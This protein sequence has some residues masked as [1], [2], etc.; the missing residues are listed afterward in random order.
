MA[1]QKRPQKRL[2]LSQ[3]ATS[4]ERQIAT[5]SRVKQDEKYRRDMYL[6]FVNSALH[7]KSMGVTE[8]FDELV[9]Q[10]NTKRTTRDQSAPA[11]QPAQLRLWFSAFSYVV[12]KLEHLHAP[13]VQTIINMPWTTLD[14]ATVKSYIVFLGNLLSAKP[15][16]LSFVLSKIAHGFTYQ[17]GLQALDNAGPEGSSGPLTRRVIY[18]RLHDLL[19]HLLSLIP[20]LPSTLQPLL[21]RNFPHKRQNQIAQTTYIRNLLRVSSYCPGLA[22]KILSTIIDRAIQID[23]EIQV[24]LEELEEAEEAKEQEELFELDPFDVVV[25][26]ES[27]SSS[28]SE[29]ETE[30]DIFSDLSSGPE[31]DDGVVVD[32]P[33]NLKQ[34][35][36]M[37]KKLDVILTLIF[38][39]FEQMYTLT[40]KSPPPPSPP[41]NASSPPLPELPPFPPVSNLF[42]S[43]PITPIYTPS[44]AIPSEK[45]LV[46]EISLLAPPDRLRAQFHA[47]LSIFDHTILRTFKSRYTQ[48]LVFWFASLDPEFADVFQGMLV[49]RALFASDSTPHNIATG[50]SAPDSHN[51]PSSTG[52]TPTVIRAAAASYIGSFVSRATFIDRTNTRHVVGVLCEFLRSHLDAVDEAIRIWGVTSVVGF[53]D[54]GVGNGAVGRAQNTVFYAVAQAVF[55]I[56]CFRWRDLLESEEGQGEDESESWKGVMDPV[57]SVSASAAATGKKWMPELGILQRVVTSILNPLKVCSPNV[58]MQFARVAHA[59][60]FLYCYSILE[61]NKRSEHAPRPSN[62]TSNHLTSTSVVH[63]AILVSETVAT[64]LNTFFPFDPYRLQRSASFIQRIYREWSSV[65]IDDEDEEDEDAEDKAG[66][67]KWY[68]ASDDSDSSGIS[69]LSDSEERK[70]ALTNGKRA[71][72][73]IPGKVSTPTNSATDGLGA[74]LDAMSISPAR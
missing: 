32:V 43:S 44:P 8:H 35:Q 74:S 65:A 55:L 40:S 29:S 52:P 46:K 57:G 60:D 72:L 64:E 49:D 58:V 22:D 26:Q 73:D 28:E 34:I 59:T 9:S 61:S 14:A 70:G 56:F 3:A 13:L 12:S 25:G 15:E 50:N 31:D 45:P 10:F 20:T 33:S 67:G 5:N 66:E 4:A 47:L 11:C 53:N 71:T 19:Q 21:V 16:Y 39:H 36:D 30:G 2:K 18:N 63:P 27:G 69:G 51:A 38:E 42:L 7:Q 62:L 23:V 41:R 68:Q 37:V 24:E 6:A 17:S 54:T 48:F 1:I